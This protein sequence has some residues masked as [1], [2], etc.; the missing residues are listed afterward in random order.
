LQWGHP[1]GRGTG[2]TRRRPV[3]LGGERLGADDPLGGV[4]QVGDDGE[5]GARGA[6]V[7]G[8]PRLGERRECPLDQR[9][10]VPL[11]LLD[12][13]PSVHEGQARSEIR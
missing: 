6:G 5:L 1:I 2:Q 12:G 13:H 8:P 3:V 10:G 7:R 9:H 4:G 11:A